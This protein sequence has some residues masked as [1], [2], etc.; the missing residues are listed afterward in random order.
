[1]YNMLWHESILLGLIEGGKNTQKAQM[2]NDILLPFWITAKC[3]LIT[4][5]K[6]MEKNMQT[7]IVST[8]PADKLASFV[9]AWTSADGA[10]MV[11]AVEGLTHW[12]RVTHICVNKLTIIGS[13]N[14]LAPGQRQAIIW[15]N[16][17]I[18]WIGNLGTNFSEILSEI[19]TFIFKKMHLN[20]SSAK[21][22][23]FWL[24]L[25]VLSHRVDPSLRQLEFNW[26]LFLVLLSITNQYC[27]SNGLA[28][29][30]I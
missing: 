26:L 2:L 27:C 22:R 1:M 24:G 15:T 12:D 11:L 28:S 3:I 17:G 21:W 30:W 7:F 16:A 29:S 8:L 20:M 25:N 9:V 13:G 10:F 4:T 5:L 18:L 14:G 6:M 19:H 23:A